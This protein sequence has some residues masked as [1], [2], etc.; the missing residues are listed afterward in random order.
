MM[1][2]TARKIFPRS[3]KSIIQFTCTSLCKPLAQRFDLRVELRIFALER[4]VL[5]AHVRH[6]CESPEPQSPRL[7]LKIML[8]AEVVG[9]N[10]QV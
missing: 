1:A 3:E 8:T 2:N 5:L 4:F 9:I 7:P 10:E 6:C